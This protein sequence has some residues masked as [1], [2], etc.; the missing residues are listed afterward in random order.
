[1]VYINTFIIP[2][3]NYK[4]LK[5][6][7]ESIRRNTPPN[8]KIILI[9]QN[10]KYQEVDDL[11]DLHIFTNGKNLGF[12]KCMNMGIRLADTEYVTCWNDDCECINKKWWDGIIET[13]DRYET[14]LGVNP[15]S[16][17]NPRAS[18]AE[19]I[20]EWEYKPDFSDE[21][22]DRLVKEHGKGHILDG[23]CIWGTVF[24]RDRLEKV[25]GAIPGKCWFDEY[26]Y[27]GGGEDYDL[28]RRAY[29]SKNEDNKLRGYRMLG[30][31]LSY[32]WHW[33]YSTKNEKGVAGVK[34]C[35]TAFADKW[36]TDASIYGQ[37]GR[38]TIPTNIIRPL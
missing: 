25:A 28:D 34:H 7:L 3:N 2:H 33:W 27:P 35:G 16:P 37:G 38:Q 12:A 10:P 18:G 5:T 6:T 23:I 1:M 36:G 13:F 24:R 22:Y 8:F 9:D 32:C 4:G 11:V 15:S 19:P 31:G 14:A 20:D 21:E 17:R 26:F 29:M 30:T